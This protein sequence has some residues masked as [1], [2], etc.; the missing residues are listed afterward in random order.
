[1]KNS[2]FFDTFSVD[3]T[4]WVGTLSD[5]S[6]SIELVEEMTKQWIYLESIFSGSDEIRRQLPSETVQFNVVNKNWK[7]MMTKWSELKIAKTLCLIAGQYEK[8]LKM[9]KSLE[10]I[11]RSLSDYLETKRMA[12]PR[13]Y[14]LSDDDLLSILGNAKSPT[15]IQRHFKTLFAGID[16]LVLKKPSNAVSEWQ[17]LG[18]QDRLNEQILFAQPVLIKGLFVCEF[19]T[20][21]FSG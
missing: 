16:C 6:D 7:I 12:F 5:I 4:S 13:F 18:F 19:V 2:P 10:K 9:Q 17:A 21:C 20:A 3:I 11:Q 1:M 8:L 15:K 14:F